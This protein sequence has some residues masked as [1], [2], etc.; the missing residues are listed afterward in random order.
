MYNTFTVLLFSH[1]KGGKC[2]DQTCVHKVSISE[3]W[4]SVRA[5]L[6]RP[7]PQ[8]HSPSVILFGATATS[9][10]STSELIACIILSVY[11]IQG[12]FQGQV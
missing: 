10:H 1:I 2:A 4:C 6:L 12:G 9:F 3:A 5:R 8:P 11:K 7:T